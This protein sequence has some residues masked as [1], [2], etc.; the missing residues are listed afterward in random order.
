[1]KKIRSS[2]LPVLM[3]TLGIFSL[4][5]STTFAATGDGMRVSPVRTEIVLQPGSSKTIS[6]FI[7][8]VTKQAATYRVIANDFIASNDESGT[9]ALLLN[10]EANDKHGLKRYMST[11]EKVTVRPNEQKEVKV[12]ITIPKGTPGGGYYGAVRFVPGGENAEGTNVA[13]SGS[14]ASLVLVRVPGDVLE[15]MSLVSFDARKDGESKVLFT[16]AKGIEATIRFRNEGNVQEQPFGKVILKKG[17][18]T[19]AT[20]EVNAG[21]QPGNVLPDSVRKFSVPLNKVGSF[22]KYT[23]EGNFGYGSA[24]QLLSAKSSFYVVPLWLVGVVVVLVLAA[25]AAFVA[26][27]RKMTRRGSR[28]RR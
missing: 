2:M 4:L 7:R 20:Y 18:T 21:D 22:G 14:V 3:T 28:S 23:I 26:L 6:V 19:L 9:P 8:N 25:V 15:K 16:S 27:K 12:T 10:G 17:N 5:V 11:V 13:L 24:G 1:M